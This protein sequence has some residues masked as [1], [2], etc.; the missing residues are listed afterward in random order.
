[1]FLCQAHPFFALL[2]RQ[3]VPA[4]RW[5]PPAIVSFPV[6]SAVS[7]PARFITR[8]GVMRWGWV[9]LLLVIAPNAGRLYAAEENPA[10][11]EY[12]EKHI[13][14]VL[15][16]QCYEC[17]AAKADSIMGGLRVD[18]R[19]SLLK[20]GD[21]GAA[22]VPKD[23]EKSL[24]I[25]ALR[26]QKFEMPPEGRLPDAT[27]QHFEQWVRM[28]APMPKSEKIAATQQK[29]KSAAKDHW[30]FQQPQQADLPE[31]ANGEWPRGEI[32][33]FVLAR[34]EEEGL[35]PVA[36]ADRRTLIRR[37]YFDLWGLPPAPE[38]VEA[39]LQDESPAAYANLIDRLLDSPR[40]G[41]RWGR[42]WL[43]VARYGESTG[44]ERNFLYPHAW[45][46]RDYVIAAFNKDKP[47]D[48]FLLEQIAG[49]QLAIQDEAERAEALTATGFL[50][51]GPRNLLGGTSQFELDEAD[52]Q[53]NVTMRAILGLT[54]GCARCHD[55]KFD[56]I[57]TKEYYGLAGI[58]LST[59]T[60]YG[61]QP[62]T[63]GGN[64][65]HPSDLIPIGPDAEKRHAVVQAHEKKV[66]EAIKDY[67]KV[68]G[69]LKKLLS[70][71]KKQQEARQKEI[72]AA[73]AETQK[74]RKKLDALK[75][76]A[77]E[78]PIYVMGVRDAK[79]I[80]DTQ[81]RISGIRPGEV[82][83]RGVLECCT[84]GKAP[85]IPKDASGRLALARWL[86]D[87]QHPL[88]ARVMVNRIWHH[89][90]GQGLVSTVDNFGTNGRAPSHPELLDWL[91]LRFQQEGWS[92][93]AMIRRMM[94]SHAY[95]LS[96]AHDAQNYTA[97]PDN[98]WQW[99]HSPRRL[100]AE[101][102]RDA[103]LAVAGRLEMSPPEDG[104]VVARLGDGCL[105]RQIDAAK[106][107]TDTPCRSVYLPAVRFF[108]PELL[109]TFD[110]ASASLVVGARAVTNVPAQAL[111]LLNNEFVIEQ[112]RHAAQR[113]LETP[114]QDQTARIVRA[115]QITFNR[116]PTNSEMERATEYLSRGRELKESEDTLWAGLFQALFASA[117]FRHVY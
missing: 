84:S 81:I 72:E 99:R 51:L 86:V 10:G 103:M 32:D 34:L 40:F 115:W 64:N 110:G 101:V 12:F 46:Y 76:Q 94:L 3:I 69:K 109:Q 105:V 113:V 4:M 89:L 31:V 47:Y 41:E 116:K 97:D 117:E 23:V 16:Q 33:R 106:L 96:S 21:H 88:T 52:D 18:N 92:I 54:V 56:P 2:D 58:F 7:R 68:F 60:L 61:T 63:G 36:D 45:R 93:K 27:I 30:A 17:H 37:A 80:A 87:P 50:A 6:R 55:H 26:Q 67:D 42:H 75:A 98:I 38:D 15:V 83:P 19:E 14:P 44:H 100:D 104:S 108:E 49:D 1:M 28:G 25:G 57:S 107:V 114:D 48:R 71:P 79:K 78:P 74:H 62:G 35:T 9:I 65:R 5:I 95:Q 22:I 85:T 13:R 77:P 102:L 8:Q 90:F 53:I 73:R 111:F 59:E 29:T 43:D 39:F 91:A 11:I 20:G 82:A 112:S 66:A 70:L 24:L